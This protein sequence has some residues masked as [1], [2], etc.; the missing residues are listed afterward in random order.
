MKSDIRDED[1]LDPKQAEMV[2]KLKRIVAISTSLM[3][4][5]FLAVMSVIAYRLVKSSE[6]TPAE[7]MAQSIPAEPGSAILSANGDGRNI[8]VRVGAE[9]GAVTVHV[10]DAETLQPRGTIATRP[11]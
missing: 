7:A 5:G 2:T 3:L 11:R 6:P 4:I 9:G 1:E 10:L 8:Y